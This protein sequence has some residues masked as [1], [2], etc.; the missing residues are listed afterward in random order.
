MSVDGVDDGG[1]GMSGEWHIESIDVLRVRCG[2]KRE[3]WRE[4]AAWVVE[5]KK[6][7]VW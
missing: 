1:C 2:I 6:A 3:R 7:Y 4:L 5:L